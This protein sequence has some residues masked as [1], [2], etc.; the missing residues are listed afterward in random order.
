M[1]MKSDYREMSSFCKSLK[2]KK[3]IC[4]NMPIFLQC[5]R[6]LKYYQRRSDRLFKLILVFQG[7]FWC[8]LYVLE[9]FVNLLDLY[10]EPL[11]W[12]M[13]KLNEYK[14]EMLT[15]TVQVHT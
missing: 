15:I 1:N 3:T 4:D 13:I 6:E 14:R 2:I 11:L 8:A 9:C 5:F 10:Y 12:F 7:S